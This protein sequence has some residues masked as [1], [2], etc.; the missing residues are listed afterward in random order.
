MRAEKGSVWGEFWSDLPLRQKP[1]LIP[2]GAQLIAGSLYGTNLWISS[3]R[4]LKD[5]Q[6]T[7]ELGVA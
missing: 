3:V 2:G 6:G 1:L 5:Q 7:R 4:S